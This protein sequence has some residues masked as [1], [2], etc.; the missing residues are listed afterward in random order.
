MPSLERLARHHAADGLL[1]LAVNHRET[2]A[3]IQRFLAQL[4]LGLTIL[5]DTDGGASQAWGAQVFPT[6][7][8]VSARGQAVFSVFGEVDWDAEPARGWVAALL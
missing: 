5:R 2:D 1:V 8:G 4:P 6:T 7:V 3:T